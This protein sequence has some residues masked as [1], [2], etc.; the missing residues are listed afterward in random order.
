ME[1]TKIRIFISSPSDVKDERDALEALIKDELQLTLGRQLNLYLEPLLWETLVTPGMGD[2]QKRVFDEVGP[3]DIFVGIFWKRFG[4][5]TDEHESGSEAEF[6]DAYARWEEDNSRPVL[7][8]FCKRPFVPETQEELAQMGKVLGFRKELENKGLYS[9]YTE[10]SEFEKMLRRHLNHCI[11]SLVKDAQPENVPNP[12]ITTSQPESAPELTPALTTESRERYLRA[13]RRDCLQIPLTVLGEGVSDSKPVKLNQVFI[14]LNV[15]QKDHRKEQEPADEEPLPALEAI[16]GLEQ[17]VLLGDPGSGKSSFVKHLLAGIAEDQS[18]KPDDLLP[19]LIV[20]R[21]LAPQLA[22]VKEKGHK[23]RQQALAKLVVAQAVADLE[24]LGVSEFAAGIHAAF[25][26]EKVFLVLDGLDEVPFDQRELVREAVGAVIAQFDLPRVFVTCRVRSYVGPAV[27]DDVPTFTLARLSQEQIEGF[28]T[29]WYEAQC[30]L[31]RMKEAKLESRSQDL[32]QVATHDPLLS[33]AGN[34]MLLTTMTIIHQQQTEL[35]KERVKLYKLAVELLLRRWQEENAGLPAVLADFLTSD[36]KV[37]PA[38]ERLAYEAHKVDAGDEAADLQRMDIIALLADSLHLGHESPASQFLDYVDLRSGLLIGRGGAPGSPAQY[39][40]PHRTFQEYLAGCYIVGA[41][42]AAAR[43]R[44]LAAA[45][46]FWSE[47]VMLGIQEQVYNSGSYGRDKVLTLA[48]QLTQK[49]PVT[50]AESRV[51]LWAGKMAEVVGAEVVE[52]DPGDIEKGKELLARLKHQFVGLLGSPLPSIERAEA[53]RTLS[54]LGDPDRSLLDVDQMQFCFVPAGPFMMGSPEG[55]DREKPQHELN[56]DYGYWIGQHTVTQSQ[57][58]EFVKE[59]GYDEKKWWTDAGWNRK[60]TWTNRE[61]KGERFDIPNH[62]VVGVSWYEAI[63]FTRWLTV[64]WKE[65]G[66][67]NDDFDVQLPNEPE[68]EKA[69]RGGITVPASPVVCRISD[70]LTTVLTEKPNMYPER[71]YPWGDAFE[72][73][74]VNVNETGVR[75]TSRSGSF[76][77]GVSPYG[78]QDAAGNVFEW[79]RNKRYPPYPYPVTVNE[80]ESLEG[81]ERRVVRG[82]SWVYDN[83]SVRCAYRDFNDP[84]DRNFYVGFRIVLLPLSLLG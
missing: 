83:G 42:G 81:D 29:R 36:E 72:I 30:V 53:G 75:S 34:P 59:G 79:Q 49:D 1:A 37:R 54:H 12:S 40:F 33:L 8:Y 46:D 31:G 27:F 82:G 48:S 4:T 6:R 78:L 68:W 22:H 67:L 77:S 18:G 52:K 70:E 9:T 20:L 65:K 13:F 74:R 66:L 60:G 55:L 24:T 28:I 63:A 51:T 23:K 19:I 44:D 47:A 57:Y 58:A 76:P 41:R 16:E 50:E 7:M 43:L 14:P 39:G 17:A 11:N 80:W 26:D 84:Y 2:I 15:T 35:P 25:S 62:P 21:D 3:Y 5:P 73:E 69:A 71:V 32:I 38:I 10:L 64:Q 56:L 61:R 45:G